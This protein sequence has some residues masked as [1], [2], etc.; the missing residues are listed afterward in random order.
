[1]FEGFP[2]QGPGSACTARASHFIAD[3]PPA[4]RILDIRCGSGMQ[5]LTLAR[6]SPESPTTPPISTSHSSMTFGREQRERDW[7]PG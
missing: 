5:T 4:C 6:L 2:R 1:M 7:V 3:I